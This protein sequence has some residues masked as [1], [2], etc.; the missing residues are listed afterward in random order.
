M[1]LLENQ[2][3]KYRQGKE[4]STLPSFWFYQIRKK[5]ILERIPLNTTIIITRMEN[6]LRKQRKNA[7]EKDGRFL[8]SAADSD[9]EVVGGSVELQRRERQVQC[10]F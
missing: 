7:W 10:Y 9:V 1:H 3:F 4:V 8:P 5:E 6:E 2:S